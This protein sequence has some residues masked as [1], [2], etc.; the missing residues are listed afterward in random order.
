LLADFYQDQA[1][2]HLSWAGYARAAEMYQRAL[3][4]QPKSGRIL[5]ALGGC[6][7]RMDEKAVAQYY[8]EQALAADPDDLSVYDQ[9]IHA[10]LDVGKPA[11]AWEV[12]AKAE[13]AVEMIPYEF[14]IN[15]AYY[16]IQR[17]SDLAR[18]WLARAAEKAPPDAPV[19]MVIGEMAVTAR[20]WEIAHEYLERAIAAGQAMG[21]AHLMLGIVDVQEGELGAAQKHWAEAERIARRERDQDLLERVQMARFLFS[22]PPGLASLLMQLGGGPFGPS[23]PDFDDDDFF[24][25]GEDENDDDDFWY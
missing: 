8:L 10:W 22:G 23:F 12:M 19:F 9:I 2:Y 5:A 11:Q 6:H 14:Y 24:S 20:A 3:E 4:Y 7:L 17:S 13:A 25:Y 15:Q 16:C 18:P 21:Q 1:D